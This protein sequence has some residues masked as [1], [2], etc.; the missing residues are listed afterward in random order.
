MKTTVNRTN[1]WHTLSDSEIEKLLPWMKII[2][3]QRMTTALLILVPLLALSVVMIVNYAIDNRWNEFLNVIWIYLLAGILVFVAAVAI[4]DYITRLN[5]FKRGDVEV[6]I[7]T[8][9]SKGISSGARRHYYSV[10]IS[11]IYVDNKDVEKKFRIPK[12][13]YDFI[14]PG[15]KAYAV[16]YNGMGNK[17]KLKVLDFLPSTEK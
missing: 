8:V 13:L 17:D 1:N 12:V 3:R 4:A 5:K 14:S 6:V 10:R 15:D 11:G 9:S 2:H 7:V 16:R